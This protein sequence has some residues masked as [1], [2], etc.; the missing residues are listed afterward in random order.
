[1]NWFLFTQLAWELPH[2]VDYD[3]DHYLCIS[4][5]KEDDIMLLMRAMKIFDAKDVR[6]IDHC[7]VATQK[8]CSIG[9][10]CDGFT[11]LLQLI[12][13]NEEKNW[14]PNS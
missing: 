12:G 14:Y 11:L 6:S 2:C 7:L 13:I 5:E 1:M 10:S 4:F 8:A 3:G 9:N